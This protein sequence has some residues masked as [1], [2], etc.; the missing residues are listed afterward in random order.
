[1]HGKVSIVVFLHMDKQDLEKVTPW[2][3]MVKIKALFLLLVMKY[4]KEL[5]QIKKKLLNSKF[6][7]QC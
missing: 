7:F 5:P 6:S 3:A 1:M 4:F 2:L